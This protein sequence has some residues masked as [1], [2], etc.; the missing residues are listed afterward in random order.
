M[1]K[2]N[3]FAALSMA[4][5]A[6]REDLKQ[7]IQRFAPLDF[8]AWVPWVD[9]MGPAGSET[10]VD[11]DEEAEDASSITESRRGSQDGGE[12][13]DTIACIPAA[14]NGGESAS[15]VSGCSTIAVAPA[16]QVEEGRA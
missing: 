1:K 14:E 12:E 8:E 13:H 16:G 4:V 9:G 7:G 15:G 5:A 3:A 11:V 10:I 2:V 6:K